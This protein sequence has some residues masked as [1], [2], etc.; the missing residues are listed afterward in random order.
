MTTQ[1]KV[2]LGKYKVGEINFSREIIIWITIVG[3][4]LSVIGIFIS[5]LLLLFLGII[6]LPGEFQII[7]DPVSPLIV[8]LIIGCLHE[9]IHG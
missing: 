1:E 5:I 6:K 2:P 4:V 9:G 8:M 7:I 3:L